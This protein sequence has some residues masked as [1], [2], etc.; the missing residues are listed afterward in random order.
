M[1]KERAGK[2]TSKRFFSRLSFSFNVVWPDDIIFAKP[3]SFLQKLALFPR[4]K[5]DRQI[6]APPSLTR[7]DELL[8]ANDQLGGFLSIE[9][10]DVL[11]LERF[12]IQ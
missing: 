6:A 3:L 8:P 5:A 12:S 7:E 10:K 2:R 11:F 9:R 4:Q 1:I